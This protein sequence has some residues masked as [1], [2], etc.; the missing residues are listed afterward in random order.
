MSTWNALRKAAVDIT[1][2][3]PVVIMLREAVLLLAA[4]AEG[5]T[6][7]LTGRMMMVTVLLLLVLLSTQG[8]SGQ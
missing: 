3:G 6:H 8:E 7:I 5:K 1:L 4:L 2:D